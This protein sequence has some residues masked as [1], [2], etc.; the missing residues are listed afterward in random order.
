M[1]R[2][3]YGVVDNKS[4][5]QRSAIVGALSADGERLSAEANQQHRLLPHM[6]EQ[7]AAVRQFSGGD[8]E[9]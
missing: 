9:R 8:S 2:A 4:L 5:R 6:T 7:L 3:A 1:P